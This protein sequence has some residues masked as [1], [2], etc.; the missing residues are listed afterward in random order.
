M[1]TP[2][3]AV[4]SAVALAVAFT[5]PATPTAAQGAKV[6]LVQHDGGYRLLVNG[7]PFFIKGGGGDGDKALLAQSGGNA[8]RTWGV[9]DDTPARLQRAADNNLMV[10]LGF[11]LGHERHGFDYDD[12]AALAEQKE[13]VRQGVLRF[14][15][16]PNV[17][18]WVIGNEM[19]GFAEGDN[20]KIWNHVQELAAMVKELDPNRPTA[21]VTAELG[22][23]RVK[24]VHEMCPD[25]DIMGIN[26]YAGGPSIP[27]RYRELGGTKPYMLTEFGP[28]GTWETGRTDFDAAP[29]LTSTQKADVYRNVWETAV[30]AER[31]K[32]CLGGFAFTWGF[33]Q[34][35]TATWFGMFLSDGSKLGAVDAMT[36]AWTGSPPDNR[37]PVVEPLTVAGGDT[38]DAGDKVTVLLK[39]SDPDGDAITVTWKLKAEAERYMTGG[40]YEDPT[41]IFADAIV[42]TTD[43]HAVV[44]LPLESGIYRLYA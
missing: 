40:D 34:E 21:T 3:R 38:A 5:L 44:E 30:A 23:A 9:G 36:E 43:S 41:E 35:A 15:D 37:C 32:L 7:E 4:L 33:K 14:R 1:K 10:A 31:D 28:P 2:L 20:P 8:F 13:M 6:E 39:A 16:H 12:E 26:S 42:E 27:T 25:I 18:M 11:W 19:E 24:S 17:L 22:G 29:E